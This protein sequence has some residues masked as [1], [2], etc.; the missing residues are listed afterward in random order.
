M[1]EPLIKFCKDGCRYP[2]WIE[3]LGKKPIFL[4]HQEAAHQF[5]HCPECGVKIKLEE[6]EDRYPVEK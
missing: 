6:L 1:K 2:F 4:D 3:F 5:F